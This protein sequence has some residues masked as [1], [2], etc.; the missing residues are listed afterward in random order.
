MIHL[1]LSI[2]TINNGGF[3]L[4]YF[5]IAMYFIFGVIFGSFFNVIG[6]RIP[7]NISFVRDY[8]H[9]PLCKERL[10]SLEL[11]PVISFIWQRG[12]CRHC[13]TRI[14]FIYPVIELITGCLFAYS[15]L[16]LGF[17]MELIASLLFISLLMIIIVSDV[18]YMIIPNSVL[19]FFLPLLFIS[20]IISPLTPWY[21]MMIG[22]T[23]GFFIIGLIIIVSKGGMGAGDMKLFFLLGII[24]GWKKVLL[25]LF[26]ASLL[27]AIVG[28]IMQAL[29]IVARKQP[30]PFGPYIA[31]AA[32][33]AY[34]HGDMMIMMY[35][36]LLY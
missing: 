26:L 7:K 23:V 35:L 27:G 19:L 8:S 5:D 21:D 30:I 24:L 25:T 9:C 33:I 2:I 6:L 29:Q 1:L 14:P 18:T 31:V 16:L 4:K 15:Y 17:Q 3:T 36:N 13:H 11:I 12:T 34:F 10:H 32:M 22:A 28:L 20:R